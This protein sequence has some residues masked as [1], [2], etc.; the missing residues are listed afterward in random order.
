MVQTGCG[1]SLEQDGPLCIV[2]MSRWLFL[3]TNDQ[4]SSSSSVVDVG[5]SGFGTRR[6]MHKRGSC[7]TFFDTTGHGDPSNPEGAGETTQTTAL[8][9]GRPAGNCQIAVRRDQPWFPP[10]GGDW[11]LFK[12]FSLSYC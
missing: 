8:L 7:A 10:R 2:A 5:S 12:T 4:S 9:K 11:R 1:S 3:R 6:V